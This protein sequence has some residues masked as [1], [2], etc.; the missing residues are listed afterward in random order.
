LPSAVAALSVLATDDDGSPD[1]VDSVVPAVRALLQ[2][3]VIRNK[4]AVL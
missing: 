4:K 1:S 2:L 3:P